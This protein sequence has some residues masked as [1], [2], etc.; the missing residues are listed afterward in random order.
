MPARLIGRAAGPTLDGRKVPVR[1][2]PGDMDTLWVQ[3]DGRRWVKAFRTGR[4]EARGLNRFEAQLYADELLARKR[5][6]KE[7]AKSPDAVLRA[8]RMC[9]L[10]EELERENNKEF[11]RLRE[12][13]LISIAGRPDAHAPVEESREE[14]PEPEQED[15]DDGREAHRVDENSSANEEKWTTVIE[16]YGDVI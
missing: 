5:I 16:E 7:K 14:H 12:E 2:N 1:R 8:M 4:T 11:R 3:V 9:N 15:Q 6:S 10:I 13:G